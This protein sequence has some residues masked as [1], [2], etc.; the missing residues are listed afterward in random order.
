MGKYDQLP[1]WIAGDRSRFIGFWN[2][3]LT[4]QFPKCCKM[5]HVC[6]YM[7]MWV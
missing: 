2:N 3:L 1:D 7:C 6:T 4:V 5:N